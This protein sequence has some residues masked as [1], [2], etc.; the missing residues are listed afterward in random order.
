MLTIKVENI[1]VVARSLT[2]YITEEV[3]CHIN[4]NAY[5]VLT[6][7]NIGVRGKNA[8]SGCSIAVHSLPEKQPN[9]YE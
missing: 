7:I 9:E 1:N 3:T 6:N 8:K 5:I 2:S 4:E